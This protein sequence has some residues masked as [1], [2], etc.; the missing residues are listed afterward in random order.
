VPPNMTAHFRP[1]NHCKRGPF[2]RPP[3]PPRH[4][5]A[6]LRAPAEAAAIWTSSPESPWIAAAPVT[7]RHSSPAFSSLGETTHG[8]NAVSGNRRLRPPPPPPPKLPLLSPAPHGDH[9]TA[10]VNKVRH[11]GVLSYTLRTCVVKLLNNIFL[12]W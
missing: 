8:A 11:A 4:F 7:L 9:W 6:E 1:E 5:T 2:S 12:D 3:P 10:L